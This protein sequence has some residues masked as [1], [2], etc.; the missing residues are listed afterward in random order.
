MIYDLFGS[1]QTSLAL[2]RIKGFA[3]SAFALGFGTVN[4][5]FL[6]FLNALYL[7]NIVSK[8]ETPLLIAL[9]VSLRTFGRSPLETNPLLFPPFFLALIKSFHFHLYVSHLLSHLC[10]CANG[11]KIYA[12]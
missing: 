1:G 4:M 7:F 6:P 2:T 3:G 11:L 10:C 5:T 8:F 9:R 12:L